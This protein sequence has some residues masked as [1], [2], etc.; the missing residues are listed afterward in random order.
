MAR[1]SSS[2]PKYTTTRI[3][4]S[5]TSIPS[6]SNP[7][8]TPNLRASKRIRES[9]ASVSVASTGAG[10]PTPRKRT[11]GTESGTPGTEGSA[12]KRRTI[13]TEDGELWTDELDAALKKG[14]AL[15]PNLG[16]RTVYFPGDD[17]SYGRNGLLSEYIRRQTGKHRNRIQVASHCAVWKKNYPSDAKLLK[18][19]IGHDIPSASISTTDWDAFLG[20]DKHP[21]TLSVA[22]KASKAKRMQAFGL[23]NSDDDVPKKGKKDDDEDSDSE[24]SDLSDDEDVKPAKRAKGRAS[25]APPPR[26]GSRPSLPRSASRRS[27]AATDSAASAAETATTDDDASAASTSLK[28]QRA[29]RKSA[30]AA[31]APSSSAPTPKRRTRQ[32]LAP[33]ST[34]A[35]SASAADVSASDAEPP[36]PRRRNAARASTAA[37]EQQLQA[38]KLSPDGIPPVPALPASLV[39]PKRA[40]KAAEEEDVA[41]EDAPAAA[42]AVEDDPL[43]TNPR[44]AAGQLDLARVSSAH[45]EAEVAA[46]QQQAEQQSGW[47]AGVKRGLWR[48]F[49]Y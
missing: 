35:A 28:P 43:H 42:A 19:I 45:S 41:M 5:S 3:S 13:R 2:A 23:D 20:P 36:T 11:R 14:L 15:I 39:S 44:P 8:S 22:R 21:E 31:P 9:S 38:G 6:S 37:G 40:A 25:L 32:S 18:L 34:S 12:T 29:P 24:L 17:E 4:A 47:L 33:V 27:L 10:T 7:A 48:A 1:S 49:G 26:K 46:A 30:P 16:K